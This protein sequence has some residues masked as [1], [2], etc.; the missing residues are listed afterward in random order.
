MSRSRIITMAIGAATALTL[1]S[2]NEA[3]AVSEEVSETS[4]PLEEGIDVGIAVGE[5][6][7]IGM[8]L[9]DRMGEPATLADAM[10]EQGLVLFFVRSADWCPYCKAQLIGTKDIAAEIG[11]SGF[12]LAS[13]SYDDPEK[14]AA[15]AAN[16]ELNFANFSD[17]GSEMIDALGLR[18]PQYAEGTFAYG[19]PRATIL[20]LAP[21]GTVLSKHVS[22][23]FKVRPSN[24]NVLQMLGGVSG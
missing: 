6:V 17:T 13:L 14:L 11:E 20:I 23:D 15:F 12:G 24:E 1:A 2:C 3:P 18:D 10:G 8:E 7:P 5:T 19:V 16:E 9:R 22:D 21:D 4:P